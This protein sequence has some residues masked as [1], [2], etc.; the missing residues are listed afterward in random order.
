M[1]VLGRALD[2]DADVANLLGLAALVLLVQRPSAIA[3]VGFQ[4]SFGATLG[5][6]L[7]TPVLVER[8]PALPLRTELA[9]AASLAAQA[10]I[11]PLLALHFN[12]LAPAALVLNLMAVP[13]S[14]AVL[15]TGVLV[16]A[17]ALAVPVVAP[18]LGDVAWI[19]AHALLVSGEPG[20]WPALETGSRHPLGKS[21]AR[22]AGATCWPKPGNTSP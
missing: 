17:A 20:R 15:V 10:A 4:L 14:A 2:L 16:L 21:P 9:L 22:A 12:R 6:L 13:L 7:L 18:L 19:A 11:T 5:I 3:D 8:L 1:I